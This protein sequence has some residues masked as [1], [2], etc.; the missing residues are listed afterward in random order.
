M[1]SML[2]IFSP[3]KET[4]KEIKKPKIIIDTREKNSLIVSELIKIG[5]EVEFKHL[6]VGDYIIKDTIIERKTVSDFM[7]SMINKR[8]IK[9]LKNMQPLKK[10]VLLIEGINEHDLYENDSN[11]HENAVRGFLLSII[12]QYEIPIIFA[13]DYEDS[14]KFLKVLANKPSKERELGINNKPRPS[15]IKEQLQFIIE[16]FPGIGPKNAKKLLTEFTSIKNI[17]LAPQE[18]IKKLI[19]KKAEIFKLVEHDYKE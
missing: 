19:G 1:K 15:N 4:I 14:A 7:G 17:L 11:I 12:L 8:L 10:K 18:E 6:H 16:G 5:C 13:Q 2:D 9:Q 3:I